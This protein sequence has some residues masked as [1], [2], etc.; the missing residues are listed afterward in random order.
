MSG[1]PPPWHL[2]GTAHAALWLVPEDRLPPWPLAPG[3]RPLRFGRRRVV[4]VF[5]VD[6]RPGGTLAYR[7]LLVALAVRHG[8]AIGGC[9]VEAW[10]DDPRSVEA[11]RA[12]WG[13]PKRLAVLSF[14][15]AAPAP[16]GSPAPPVAP[17]P[18]GTTSPPD[19]SP[20]DTALPSTPAPPTA[21]PD[22]PWRGTPPPTGPRAE[23]A[24]PGGGRAPQATA[25]HCPL[26]RLPGRLPVRAR[27]FQPAPD[28]HGSPLQVPLR[29]TGSAWLT[30]TSLRT[31][32][33]APLGYLAGLRPL[34]AC[35]LRDFHFTI[36]R[37]VRPPRRR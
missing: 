11:G 25:L 31:A 20:P 15:P 12:L 22:G 13:I 23:E 28:A 4:G 1:P 9:A 3:V 14:G 21:S 6:Y 29:A 18:P 34:A 37:A 36:G 32:P 8:T 10:V 30:R 2:R 33:G 7:E 24:R 35:T 26:L 27:L 16:P 19:T 5:W 17:A